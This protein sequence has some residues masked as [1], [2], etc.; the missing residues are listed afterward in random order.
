MP[1]A[2]KSFTAQI[3]ALEVGESHVRLERVPVTKATED[4][5]K[6]ALDLTRNGVAQITN[7][8]RKANKGDF[9]V[10]SVTMLSPD[11]KSVFCMAVTTR[12]ESEEIDI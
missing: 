1:R 5:I 7:R 9:A 8:L 4:A 11:R 6:A 2:S 10:E 3:E 12:T